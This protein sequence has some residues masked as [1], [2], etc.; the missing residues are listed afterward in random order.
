MDP[1]FGEVSPE[2]ALILI[3][4]HSNDP[5]FMIVDVRTPAEFL[6]EHLE[7]AVNIDVNAPHFQQVI[8][9][10]DKE[11]TYLVYCGSGMRSGQAAGLMRQLG[12]A[13]VYELAGGINALEQLD[14]KELPLE[15]CGCD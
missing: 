8:E 1:A 7:N 2:T 13:R 6:P 3:A 11:R 5:E 15:S 4:E 14:G 9:G 12:F 10:L